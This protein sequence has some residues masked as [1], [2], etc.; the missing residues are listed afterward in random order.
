G[1]AVIARDTWSAI[2]GRESLQVQ[3]DDGAHGDFDSIRHAK[4]LLASV[5]KPGT[6]VREFGE[7]KGDSSTAQTIT[8]DYSL[9]HLAH[10]SMETPCATARLTDD[11]AELWMTTQAP[12]GAQQRIAQALGLSPEMVTI[13]VTLLG[14]G[15]G[16]KSK[17][18]FGVEAALLAREVGAPV[19]V[20][21]TREDDLQ[22]DYFHAAS[23]MHFE[24]TLDAQGNPTAWLQRTAFTPIGY[25][26]NPAAKHGGGGELSLGFTDIPYDLP[27]LKVESCPAE[28]HVRVG[29]LR[30]VCNVFHACGVGCFTDELAAAAGRDPMEYL[31]ERI[32]PARHVDLESLGLPNYD[33]YGSPIDKYPLD[34]GRLRAVLEKAGEMAQWKTRAPLNPD[35]D[36]IRRGLGVAAHRS[37]L[38]YVANVVEVEVDAA[39]NLT[40][41]R[42]HVAVDCGLAIHPDRVHAQMEGAVV[43]GTSLTRFGAITGKDGRIEQSNFHDYPV[44]RTMDAPAEIEV[45]IM[46]SEEPPTGVGEIGVPPFAPALL[47]AVFAATG[48]RIRDLPLSGHDLKKA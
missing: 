9:P 21:W 19:Q 18:D 4:D 33:N 39:G 5:A 15:F 35:K 10:A 30:S 8:A 37:F 20:V 40:I 43:F 3:W 22:H 6:V 1:I 13:H 44:A 32:G 47:N 16:R 48:R 24:A 14:G 27:Q 26:F 28:T 45:H 41:P 11:G 7:S 31:L 2:K 23:A 17:P 12:Q 42:V 36:G 29:W 46:P 34:T 25:T 38:G